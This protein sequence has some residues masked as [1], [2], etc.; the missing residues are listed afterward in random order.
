MSERMLIEKLPELTDSS[1]WDSVDVLKNRRKLNEIVEIL[2]SLGEAVSVDT[3][4][5]GYMALS[6]ERFIRELDDMSK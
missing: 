1:P 6:P 3:L 5:G 4:A 2:N